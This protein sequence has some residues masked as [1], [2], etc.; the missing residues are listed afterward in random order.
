MRLI[1][2]R[3]HHLLPCPTTIQHFQWLPIGSFECGAGLQLPGGGSAGVHPQFNLIATVLDA[4]D[5]TMQAC[6]G[7][8]PRVEVK[9][10]TLH[11]SKNTVFSCQKRLLQ[12]QSRASLTRS[13]ETVDH[14][15][16]IL[17]SN[18]MPVSVASSQAALAL[19]LRSWLCT[20]G[21]KWLRTLED[22]PSSFSTFASQLSST[23]YQRFLLIWELR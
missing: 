1:V 13:P 4:L 3:D 21:M 2:V 8:V 22:I 14:H 9:R 6:P 17:P 5:R 11:A 20:P 18:V 23:S 10:G 16:L 19:P 7:T 12:E 15:R